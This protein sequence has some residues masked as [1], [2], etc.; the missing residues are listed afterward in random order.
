M[1][2]VMAFLLGFDVMSPFYIK[3][4]FLDYTLLGVFP[5][6]VIGWKLRKK[7]QYHHPK[8]ADLTLGGAVK[9][10]EEYED[11]V[12]PTPEGWVEK[13]SVVFGSGGVSLEWSGRD[14]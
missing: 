8:D 9:E 4:F 2:T 6:A 11:L 5:I 12:Q 13:C 7:T 1:T 14:R 10:I 3:W